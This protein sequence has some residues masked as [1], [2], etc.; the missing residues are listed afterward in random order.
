MTT[1]WYNSK[2]SSSSLDL[3]SPIR[4]RRL[5]RV[6][7]CCVEVTLLN[8]ISRSQE[9]V[10][11]STPSHPC[12]L[13]GYS[14][15]LDCFEDVYLAE[16]EVS[17]SEG[18]RILQVVKVY[19]ELVWDIHFPGKWTTKEEKENEVRQNWRRQKC[20]K[21]VCMKA[22]RKK[23]QLI[24]LSPLRV[25]NNTDRWEDNSDDVCIIRPAECDRVL[26]WDGHKLNQ[27][28]YDWKGGK[29]EQRCKLKVKMNV[30]SVLMTL[31]GC[32]HKDCW[33]GRVGVHTNTTVQDLTL[34][35]GPRDV[36]LTPLLAPSPPLYLNAPGLKGCSA[37]TLA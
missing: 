3:P 28:Q 8:S 22:P 9:L 34:R 27:G 17:S 7:S 31:E 33:W 23:H 12:R 10:Q 19:V 21:H 1:I 20:R 4:Q 30:Y 18:W 11:F 15:C 36:L 26:R 32:K 2:S 16:T 6:R 14:V 13:K 35:S 29:Q 25:I 5:L 37:V 24:R